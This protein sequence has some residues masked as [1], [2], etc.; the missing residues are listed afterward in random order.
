[1]YSSTSSVKIANAT[2]KTKSCFSK[3]VSFKPVPL[4]QI[5]DAARLSAGREVELRRRWSRCYRREAVVLWSVTYE[6]GCA[7]LCLSQSRLFM[8]TSSWRRS[9]SRIPMRFARRLV[10]R[11]LQLQS[12]GW[13]KQQLTIKKIERIPRKSTSEVFPPY[14]S[15][16]TCF[17]WDDSG[18]LQITHKMWYIGAARHFI[19][20][21]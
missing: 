15:W 14:R 16:S 19:E 17:D 18:S 9:N 21:L 10:G 4:E 6:G 1:M 11:R 3:K 7:M 5:N 20:N 2:R 8:E 13:S 12:Y